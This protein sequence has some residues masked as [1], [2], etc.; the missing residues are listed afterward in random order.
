[1]VSA[2]ELLRLSDLLQ[3]WPGRR[4][5]AEIVT[6]FKMIKVMH[7]AAVK[8]NQKSK[9]KISPWSQML[10]PD[11]RHWPQNADAG[12]KLYTVV[13]DCRCWPRTAYNSPRLQTLVLDSRHWLWTADIPDCRHW[14]R[15]ADAG[16]VLHTLVSDCIHGPWTVYTGPGLQMLALECRYQS[17]TADAGPNYRCWLQNGL[18]HTL[19]S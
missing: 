2:S 14:P 4:V 1:M 16:P 18:G 15:T 13:P 9:M 7:R 17:Q 12:P 11:C 10:A 8:S 19:P 5:Q 6:L 3:V